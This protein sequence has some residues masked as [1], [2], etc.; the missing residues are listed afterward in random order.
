MTV[1][2]SEIY[3]LA[4]VSHQIPSLGATRRAPVEANVAG[5]S[6]PDRLVFSVLKTRLMVKCETRD[7]I[8]VIADFR[9]ILVGKYQVEKS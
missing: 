2:I 7:K 8:R 6:L 4:P 9:G 1:S 3:G 5:V